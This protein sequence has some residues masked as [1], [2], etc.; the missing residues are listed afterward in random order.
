[1]DRFDRLAW[2][3]AGQVLMALSGKMGRRGSFPSLAIIFPVM[4]ALFMASVLPAVA[5]DPGTLPTGGRI[6]SGRGNI[7]ISGN[8]MTVLQQQEKMIANW[9]T[10]NIG[11]NAG[12]TFIQPSSTS[13]ALNRILDQ[14]PSQ[15]LGSL[16]SNGQVFLLNPNGII[17]GTT[18]R[19]DVG[20]LVASSLQL[21]DADYL[22]GN[23]QFASGASAGAI[24]NYGSIITAEHGIVAL[25]APQANNYGTISAPSGTVAL[26]SGNRV[27]LDFAGDGLIKLSVDESALNAAVR[28]NGAIKADGGQ[29]IMTAKAAGDL[30]ATVI[31]NS[32]IIEANSIGKKNGVIVLD[33]GET[34]IVSNSGS[35]S[36]AGAKNGETGG[37]ITLTGDKVGLLAG[38]AI[39][40]SGYAGGGTVN[41]G[42]GWQGANPGIRNASKVYM[43]PAASI[44]AD[45]TTLGNG[46]TVALWSNNY[47]NFQGS[48]SARGGILGGNGGNVETSSADILLAA[49]KVSTLAP[50]GSAGNWLLDPSDIYISYTGSDP[51]TNG[52]YDPT[53]SYGYISPDTILAG[54]KNGNV[55]IQTHSGS[56]G[57][58]DIYL[59]DSIVV[60][61]EL[62]G[63]RTLAL[64][65]DRDI[66]F[67]YDQV[68]DATGAVTLDGSLATAGK[69]AGANSSPLNVV[70]WSNFS[71]TGGSIVLYPGSGIW[72]N[73]GNITLG[74]GSDMTTGYAQGRDTGEETSSGIALINAQLHSG[75]GDVTLRGKG[76]GSDTSG[77]YG[78]GVFLGV[79]S[80][81][82][83]VDTVIDS[84]SGKISITGLAA[85]NS[86]YSFNAGV[87]L[88]TGD[89][90]G[91]TA[92]VVT[93]KSSNNSE[94]AITILGDAS[95]STLAYNSVGVALG[96]GATVQATGGGGIQ[97]TGYSGASS[98]A[99]NY[100]VF[101]YDANILANSGPINITGIGGS[102][103]S[104]NYAIFSTTSTRIGQ[105]AGSDVTS[106][107]SNITMTGD[108][109]YVAGTLQT[110]GIFTVQPYTASTSIGVGSGAPGTLR[111]DG[112]DISD[113]SFTGE[114]IIGRSD[115]TG[116]ITIGDCNPWSSTTVLNTGAGS[117]GIVLNGVLTVDGNITLATTGPFVN[118]YG[119]NAL[120][121]NGGRWLVYSADPSLNTLNGLTPG[122]IQYNAAYSTTPLGSGSG[123][124]YSLAPTITVSLTGSVTKEYDGTSA[125]TLTDANYTYTGALTGDTVT[126]N[127]PTSGAYDNALPGT[128][129]MVSTTGLSVAGASQGGVPV[130]GYKITSAASGR[131]G[132]IT[133]SAATEKAE[134]VEAA[135]TSTQ[136]TQTDTNTETT[137]PE[138]VEAEVQAAEADLIELA[139]AEGALSPFQT[140][141]GF[142]EQGLSSQRSGDYWNAVVNFREAADMLLQQSS[143]PNAR[144]AIEL[145]KA[146]ELQAYFQDGSI[147]DQMHKTRL[148]DIPKDS[149]VVYTLIFPKRVDLVLM[150]RS[151]LKKFTVPVDSESLERDINKLR[152]S[153]ERRTRWDFLADSQHLYKLIV[154]PLEIELNLH[155][156]NTLIFMPDGVLRT[157][158]F[159]ALHDGS[160]FLIE[161]YAVVV[162][163]SLNLTDPRSLKRRDTR[164]LSAGLTESVQ[165]FAPLA[166][167]K[168]E[169]DGIQSIYGADRLENRS[170]VE[171][172][173]SQSLKGNPYSIVHIATHGKFAPSATDTYLLAWDGRIDMNQLDSLMRQ[174]GGRNAPIELLFLSAC[175]TAAGDDKAALGL[176][177]V[178]VKAGARSALA[179]LWSVSDQAASELVLEF[180]K[181]LQNPSITKAEALQA[182][183]LKLIDDA[184]YRHPFFWSPFLLIG[185]WM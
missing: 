68:I 72:S 41:I 25:I 119:A 184:R 56:G 128:D 48:I 86:E 13:T 175:E 147:A 164:V 183:Q 129:K 10:F 179:T 42:G 35:I 141:G 94:S 168:D 18:A 181:Q 44:T 78:T 4:V 173:V 43:D 62:G 172:N 17:F 50:K 83:S 95:G 140:A 14:N 88:A 67:Q 47:T 167:V 5:I 165:G 16:K 177:G 31:N 156:I 32:G 101:I 162:T 36:A 7:S 104:A 3:A 163:P 117:A 99:A 118:N 1:M 45:A 166:N 142:T 12:V 15:I 136:T 34:G 135:V 107:S 176:A 73:G 144:E 89:W 108:E 27:A 171:A 122:F 40:A 71:N 116:L 60:T 52:I 91:G 79:E 185:N 70:L 106:S 82:E 74:G 87:A 29:V 19:I 26:A 57:D 37:T 161:K 160:R 51:L 158:P 54:L 120:V 150:L 20:G 11:Q 148:K 111:T 138:G 169:L 127:Y 58:G 134:S 28:N 146:A 125:A 30:T 59:E 131:V 6:V 33:G 97:L 153:L 84:G 155:G 93:I 61:S 145:M 121:A 100:G 24:A 64:K 102:S 46:G 170:F 126:L 8:Q 159:A 180:Y 9:N 75:G 114:I 81:L 98:S 174:S 178:A 76:A 151:G 49:G 92:N 109:I 65:A 115:G 21:S 69:E 96:P 66:I 63:A 90:V 143:L 139:S 38:S 123:L 152:A 112:W 133:G 132:T 124:L 2:G 77:Y 154:R 105:L 80:D 103:T 157:V 53:G 110:T 130:Y 23:F 113:S 149:A 39:D 182:A 55:T 85:M 22:S 137:D